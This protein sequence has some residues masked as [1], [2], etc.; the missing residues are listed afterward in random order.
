[1]S[2]VLPNVSK[3]FSFEIIS[4]TYYENSVWL[5]HVLTDLTEYD[6]GSIKDLT[7]EISL[8][9]LTLKHTFQKLN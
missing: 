2:V 1:M 3:Y 6:C 5:L 7:E 9:T 4:L 8:L